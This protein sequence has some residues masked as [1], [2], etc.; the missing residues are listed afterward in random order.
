MIERLLPLEDYG[1]RLVVFGI[2]FALLIFGAFGPVRRE[3]REPLYKGVRDSQNPHV[4]NNER[5][6]KVPNFVEPKFVR[7]T[8]VLE[9]DIL[10]SDLIHLQEETQR[11]E[12]LSWD[13]VS[14]ANYWRKGNGEEPDST[15]IPPDFPDLD[16]KEQVRILE[17][18]K[19]KLP[20]NHAIAGAGKL[21]DFERGELAIN[22]I[23]D[24]R[25]NELE[26]VRNLYRD[27]LGVKFS[28]GWR[29]A[30]EEWWW[31]ASWGMTR[32]DAPTK[33]VPGGMWII[34]SWST[35][36]SGITFGFFLDSTSKGAVGYA[37]ML[38]VLGLVFRFQP[39]YFLTVWVSMILC[40]LS[41]TGSIWIMHLF[42]MYQTAYSLPPEIVSA[43]FEISF[44]VQ[45]MEIVR[46][47]RYTQPDPVKRWRE[48]LEEMRGS[49]NRITGAA[50]FG[51]TIYGFWFWNIARAFEMDM[52]Y[53]SGTFIARAVAL[54]FQP[55]LYLFAVRNGERE[56]R[57]W[58]WAWKL[59][60]ATEYAVNGVARFFSSIAFAF[61]RVKNLR[62]AA[63]ALL[64]LLAL[65]V[66]MAWMEGRFDFTARPL[67]YMP[68]DSNHIMAAKRANEG[69]GSD[70]IKFL[71]GS[72]EKKDCLKEMQ[73]FQKLV[74]FQGDV[75]KLP[76]V[77][78]SFSIAQ[79]V[80]YQIEERPEDSFENIVADVLAGEFQT[81]PRLR[82]YLNPEGSGMVLIFA[83]HPMSNS[84]GTGAAF[85]AG[86]LL[87]RRSGKDNPGYEAFSLGDQPFY[88]EMARMLPEQFPWFVLSTIVSI[89]LFAA[90]FM[91]SGSDEWVREMFF[92]AFLRR[93]RADEKHMHVPA[94]RIGFALA[95]PFVFGTCVVAIIML[96]FGIALEIATSAIVPTVLACASDA[97]FYP[98]IRFLELLDE[99]V[100]PKIAMRRAL[101]EKGN[102]VVVD[103]GTNSVGLLPLTIS[104]FS[105][106]AYLGL[107]ATIAINASIPWSLAVALPI[108]EAGV[109]SKEDRHERPGDVFAGDPGG[110]RV[111]DNL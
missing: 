3:T 72:P 64:A 74:A 40:V 81:N 95:S 98:A 109:K 47:K 102:A 39:Q 23:L 45:L 110:R 63:N 42:G 59:C 20:K 33:V 69:A 41:T 86:L 99:G 73:C 62:N 16:L 89:A 108:M 17:E 103:G 18:L 15:W 11:Y 67:E 111:V 83:Q 26:Q 35:L 76:G 79:E 93:N 92:A 5:A 53:L 55:A 9:R 46:K 107:L 56:A 19:Q 84:E 31:N 78:G 22:V 12:G 6:S 85:D 87:T 65:I 28:D 60:D 105:P 58:W 36:R 68:Q 94:W 8:L 96:I 30:I 66:G 21:V 24:A 91:R 101:E 34:E 88:V 32:W 106:V 13:V 14:L 48:A 43:I 82:Q 37:P 27:F 51:F 97:C 49:I 7:L 100:H 38:V 50:V 54:H 61:A 29:G 75:E 44:G 70:G 10:P 104:M 2:A 57:L 90:L 25:G 71:F 52:L 77:R 80:S 4:I 1:K